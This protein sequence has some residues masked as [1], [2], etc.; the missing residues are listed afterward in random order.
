M[1]WKFRKHK[2]AL[3][4]TAVLALFL[5]IALAAEVLSPSTPFA[6]DTEYVLGPPQLMRF[7]DA[8]G[9]WHAA[10]VCAQRQERDPVTLRMRYKEDPAERIPVRF[11]VHGEPYV[12]WGLFAS[13]VHLIGLEGGSL[14]ILGTDDLGRDVL[15]RVLYGT[16]ISLSIGVIGVLI[17]FVLGLLLGGIA[18]YAG[19][20]IDG[21]I[22]RFTEFIRSIP[23]LPL[24]MALSASLPI[25]WTGL[26]VYLAITVILGFLGWTSLARRVRGKLLSLR[27]EDY[28][29]AARICGCSDGRIVSRHMLPSFLSYLIVDI[30]VSFPNMILGETAL[31]FI[32]LGLRP[33]IVSWGVLL[34][35]AQSIQTLAMQPWLLSPVAFIVLAVL[36]FSFV[37]DGLRDA[38]DPYSR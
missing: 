36:A 19:G 17:S 24:W 10:F 13:D 35:S 9:K 8:A 34:Q 3:A 28:I 16:R 1:W 27:E 14:H 30:T 29:M 37:G 26:Q 22:Q 7:V 33:P 21:L 32:G 4:G 11:W 5:L 15:T 18:G 12:L 38:A 23:S 31:S 25:G 20:W 2:L 6:R